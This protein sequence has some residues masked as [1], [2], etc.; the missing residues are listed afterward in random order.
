[1]AAGSPVLSVENARRAYGTRQ[2]LAGVSLTLAAGE[3]YALVG[4]NGAGKTTLIRAICGRARLDAGSVRLD[5]ADPAADAAA[6]RRL[7]LV[8]QEIALYPDLTALEN[9]EVL[10]QLAG[11]PAAESRRRAREALNWI[12]LSDRA[13]SRVSTLSGGMKRRVNIAAGVLHEPALLL[14][15]EPTVGVDPQARERIHEMLASLRARGLAILLTTH[16]L[17]QAALLADRIGIL[18]DGALRAEGTLSQLIASTLGRARE[19]TVRLGAPPSGDRQ[20][21]AIS[22]VGLAPDPAE[23]LKLQGIV[24]GEFV[25]S[26]MALGTLVEAGLLVLELSVR[27]P[28][29]YGV[30][31][32]V[33]GKELA[34]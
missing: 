15:D 27:E 16:D 11:L 28:S 13:S 26:V 33:T 8:P 34:E 10:G 21:A 32:H 25:E 22:R 12:G 23:P 17:D 19:L 24:A 4:R 30:F 14:L 3:I 18:D 20:Q 6:R 31:F 1:M 2:A 29:L 5:G 7:G 9:L